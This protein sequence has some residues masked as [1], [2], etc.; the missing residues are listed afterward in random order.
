MVE[1]VQGGL[2]EPAGMNLSW[3]WAFIFEEHSGR[4][5]AKVGDL[6]EKEISL[7]E[8]LRPG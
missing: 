6:G 2:W 8:V 5:R 3:N 1:L 4:R 7:N